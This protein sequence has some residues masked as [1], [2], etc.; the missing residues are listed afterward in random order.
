MPSYVSQSSALL[1]WQWKQL[2]L[3]EQGLPRACAFAVFLPS[4]L[5]QAY[6]RL[7]FTFFRYQLRYCFLRKAFFNLLFWTCFFFRLGT[8]YY[9]TLYVGFMFLSR[10]SPWKPKL[11][12]KR[13]I[14]CFIK[15]MYAQS[16]SRVSPIIGAQQY[17]LNGD[18]IISIDRIHWEGF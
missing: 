9:L 5:C 13:S 10:I 17:V 4:S 8:N 14:V 2:T 12:E 16:L 15:H 7:F 1:S 6:V 18:W 11:P 3:M